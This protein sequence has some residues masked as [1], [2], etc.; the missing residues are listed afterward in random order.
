MLDARTAITTVRTCA[1]N[2]T[3]ARAAQLMWD[4]DIGALPVV[5]ANN[6]VVAMITDRDICMA[7]Y[8]RGSLLADMLVRDVMSRGVATCYDHMS[9]RE[10][11]N[12]MAERQV[13]RIPVIDGKRNLVGMV[14]LNDLARAPRR[15]HPVPANEVAETLAS[16]GEPRRQAAA[17]A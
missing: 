8:T 11:A 16:V 6:Q 10:V 7:A 14:S 15:G 12:V 1:P 5:D 4:H 9:D 3:V 13:R 2:D 17:S